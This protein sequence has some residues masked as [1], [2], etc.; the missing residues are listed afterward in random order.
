VNTRFVELVGCREPVQLAGMGPVCSDELCAAVS[1]AGGLGMITVAAT[2]AN[3]LQ[4]RLERITSM[5]SRPV[6]AN[7][8]VPLV[9]EECLRIASRTVRLIDFFWGDPDPNLVRA[10]HDGGALASWQVGSGAEAVAAQRAGCDVVIAQGDRG[11]RSHPRHIRA[12]S[13]A[14]PGS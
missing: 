12:P 13:L 5:T 10:A 4:A 2:S 3:A 9:D 1:E 11:G 6:G 14:V 8:L 7:F